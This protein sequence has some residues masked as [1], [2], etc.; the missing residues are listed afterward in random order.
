MPK[1][2]VLLHAMNIQ[3]FNIAIYID[4]QLPNPVREHAKVSENQV[5]FMPFAPVLPPQHVAGH[6][7]RRRRN[8]LVLLEAEPRLS[9]PESPPPLRRHRPSHC[10]ETQGPP[11]PPH[12]RCPFLAARRP[13]LALTRT[14][15]L[16]RAYRSFSLLRRERNRRRRPSCP[17]PAPT[18]APGIPIPPPTTCHG[19]D[20]YVP[21]RY[22]LPS[23]PWEVQRFGESVLFE[24]ADLPCWWDVCKKPLVIWYF[25]WEWLVQGKQG[26]RGKERRTHRIDTLA[27]YVC[28]L[29]AAWTAPSLSTAQV[30]PKLCFRFSIRRFY[31]QKRCKMS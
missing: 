7:R 16:D 31:L 2:L 20:D 12:L 17:V 6:R 22:D 4:D 27:G 26:R 5:L 11:T 23:V 3:I 25:F 14:R 30:P 8:P 15:K 18:P 13:P 9:H 10:W 24:V 1:E 28:S 19:F 21:G 29:A